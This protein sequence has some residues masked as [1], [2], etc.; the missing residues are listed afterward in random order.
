MKRLTTFVCQIKVIF[1]FLRFVDIKNDHS[2]FIGFLI[3]S[4]VRKLKL[5]NRALLV[6]NFGVTR[7]KQKSP[8]NLVDQFQN[9]P[10]TGPSVNRNVRFF[11]FGAIQGRV[12]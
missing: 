10:D 7:N 4:V 2:L 1:F 12:L 6:N 3:V 8:S 11:S 9:K 5:Q